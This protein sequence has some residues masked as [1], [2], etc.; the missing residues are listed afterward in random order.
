MREVA[1]KGS[2]AGLIQGERAELSQTP[3]GLEP[4]VICEW[5]VQH[6]HLRCTLEYVLDAGAIR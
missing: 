1:C 2:D 5:H 6:L 3:D 4:V